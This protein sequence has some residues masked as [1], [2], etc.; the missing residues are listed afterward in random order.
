[1]YIR[2]KGKKKSGTS[3]GT[4]TQRT[5]EKCVGESDAKKS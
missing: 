2:K 5:Q 1:M 3:F 4:L